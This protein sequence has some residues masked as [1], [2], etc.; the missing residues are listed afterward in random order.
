MGQR[1]KTK[2]HSVLWQVITLD[3]ITSSEKIAIYA[4]RALQRWLRPEND[5][6][7]GDAVVHTRF[8]FSLYVFLKKKNYE[9]ITPAY[10]YYALLLFPGCYEHVYVFRI[11][12]VIMQL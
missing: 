7:F 11:L 2:L 9:F 5:E 4:P 12:G 1:R 3:F 8:Y 6:S 10:S